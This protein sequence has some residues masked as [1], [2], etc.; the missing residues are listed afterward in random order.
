M[1]GNGRW[2]K[3]RRLPRIAGHKAGVDAVHRAVQYCVDNHIE[4]L[5]IFAFSSENW[6]RPLQEVSFLMGLFVTVLERETKKLHEKNIQFKIIGDRSH[7]D[8]R[9][10]AC[11]SNAEELMK[12]NTGLKFTVAANY[13]GQWDICNATTSI[14]EDVKNNRL[15]L[16]D[17][18]NQLIE[19]RLTTAG[20]PNPDLLIRTSGEQ[21]ISN[22]LLWQLA[23]AEIYF[24]DVLWPD[25]DENEF[26]KAI[27]FY[28]NRERRFGFISEQIRTDSNA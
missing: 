26:N 23:Y 13:G 27:A 8:K 22:F 16:S 10:Q 9:L 4:A 21:R 24:T 14:A 11:M 5:T 17:I 18:S 15:S 12:N 7:F 6:R 25:F 20:L 1:D 28:S 3:N 19:S 2:A